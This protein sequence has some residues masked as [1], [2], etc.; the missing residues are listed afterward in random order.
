MSDKFLS[1]EYGAWLKALKE[2]IRQSQIKAALSVNAELILLY[3]E[4]GRQ[5][6]EKQKNSD[7]GSGFID[8][9]SADLKREFPGMNGFS[10][11]N[12]FAMKKFHSFYQNLP[13]LIPHAGGHFTLPA[14]DLKIPQAG[15]QMAEHPVLSLCCLIPWK[16]NVLI[17]EKLK[18]PAQVI[19]YL[20]KTVENSWSRA[21][22]EYQIE[23][24]LFG[25]QGKAVTNFKQTL[26]QV[27]SDLA[28][29]LLKDPY[30]LEFIEL[31]EKAREL[32]LEQKLIQHI[33][34]FLL[35]LGKGFAYMGRQ[36]L[37]KVGR[38]EYR[39]D[40]LFYHTKLK[41]YIII[42]LKLR[43]F[44]PEFVGKLGF[45]ITAVN[46][47]VKDDNDHATIGILLCKNKDNYEVE[48]S[49]KDVNSPIGVSEYTYTELPADIQE[50][51]PSA[52]QLKNKLKDAEEND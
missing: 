44:E 17:I 37:L 15:G 38:K 12:L 46:E 11:T 5:I 6:V 51:L 36:F 23:S 35:E 34:Q 3:W 33:S 9:L 29:D 7:W 27:Q 26:P 22:L 32:E 49:L 19:F 31:S 25:R 43:E 41:C 30:N 42:E 39:T 21:V 13:E 16:H 28:H 50:N 24:N 1:E 2:Q 8:R 47:L 20:A 14:K 4:M 48:F 40:L 18:D 10:R 52:E 45:Y